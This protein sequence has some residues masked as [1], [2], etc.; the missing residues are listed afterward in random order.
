MFKRI[1]IIAKIFYYVLHLTFNM[2]LSEEPKEG[3][4]ASF[5]AVIG[6]CGVQAL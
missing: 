5:Y 4:R 1:Y 3:Q 2:F 6:I